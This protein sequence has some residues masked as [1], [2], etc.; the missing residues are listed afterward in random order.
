VG[1]PD[2]AQQK[3]VEVACEATHANNLGMSWAENGAAL[4]RLQAEGVQVREFPDDVWD[5]FGAAAAQ[6]REENMGDPIYAEIAEATSPVDGERSPAGSR[7]ATAS[8]SVSA[9][10]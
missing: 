7:S 5:A 8:T 3:I 6:V 9:T 2:P 1:E 4:A 10:A